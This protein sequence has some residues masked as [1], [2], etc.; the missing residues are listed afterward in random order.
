MTR[1][2]SEW[3]ATATNELLEIGYRAKESGGEIPNIEECWR[4]AIWAANRE[5]DE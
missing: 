5:W 4:R 3:L 2:L 1:S